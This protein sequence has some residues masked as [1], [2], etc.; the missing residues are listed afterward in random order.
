MKKLASVADQ[1]AFNETHQVTHATEVCAAAP[2]GDITCSMQ[3]PPEKA[4]E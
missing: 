1:L 4:P 2:G 3:Q